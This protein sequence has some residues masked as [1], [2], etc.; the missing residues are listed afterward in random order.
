ME[1]GGNLD[2]GVLGFL[3]I[4]FFFLSVSYSS[5]IP[6]F[7]F[8]STFF[9]VLL[10]FFLNFPPS[11][12]LVF[13]LFSLLISPLTSS[14]FYLTFN[15]FPPR[16]VAMPRLVICHEFRLK[17]ACVIKGSIQRN[18]SQQKTL[19]ILTMSRFLALCL[20]GT[21][22]LLMGPRFLPSENF[23]DANSRGLSKGF[24]VK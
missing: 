19:I 20:T 6:F 17:L 15:T 1:D 8:F 10:L 14:R 7:S 11:F 12:S 18:I 22:P 23:S 3:S 16:P 4:P 2:L 9:C 13:F 21:S 5:F 24:V